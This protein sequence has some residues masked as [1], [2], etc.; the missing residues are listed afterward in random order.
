MH[1]YND[2]EP[3]QPFTNK[4]FLWSL[5]TI[6]TVWIL[7]NCQLQ[8][9]SSHVLII[10]FSKSFSIKIDQ[11]WPLSSPTNTKE[12]VYRLDFDLKEQHQYLLLYLES[13]WSLK[14]FYTNSQNTT[15]Q[16]KHSF[17]SKQVKL[18][19]RS[20]ISQKPLYYSLREQPMPQLSYIQPL[21]T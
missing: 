5:S 16:N 9:E 12:H 20:W 17:T 2:H 11:H 19:P 13:F 10:R 15:Y 7:S 3:W 1:L 14:Q 8:M 6:G 21:W 4:F 18:A